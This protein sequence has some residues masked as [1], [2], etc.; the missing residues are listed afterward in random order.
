MRASGRGDGKGYS[1]WILPLG[2]FL[3]TLLVS[4]CVHSK[5]KLELAETYYNLGN[6]YAELGQWEDAS[7]A[8]LRAVELDPSLRRAGYQRALVYMEAEE[9]E[10]AEE[11]LTSLLSEDPENQKIQENLAWLYIRS[12][13]EDE[14]R[15]LYENILERNPADCDVRYNFALLE[16]EEERWESTR[17]ILDECLRYE[18][19]DGE[20]YRLLGKAGMEL[21]EEEGVGFLEKAYEEDSSLPGIEKELAAAYR[22]VEQYESA[23]DMY[24]NIIRKIEDTEEDTKEAGKYYFEKAYIYF[25]AMEDYERGEEAL[26]EALEKGFRDEEE[27]ASLASFPRLLDPERILDILEEYDIELPDEPLE[28]ERGDDLD[29]SG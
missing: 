20:I 28:D 17:D 2:I 15:R 25:T 13:R 22:K 24:D 10:K 19:A 26:A 29:E 21:G 4:G 27:L 9:Y 23:V 18:A 5:T 8:Y 7:K 12:G 14:A 6:V 3:F 1:L 11:Q 16:A